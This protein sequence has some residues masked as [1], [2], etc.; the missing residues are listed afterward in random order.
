MAI[1]RGKKKLFQ[2]DWAAVFEPENVMAEIK[3]ITAGTSAARK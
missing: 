1:E 3:A 2:P